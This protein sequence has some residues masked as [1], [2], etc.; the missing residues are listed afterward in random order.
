MLQARWDTYQSSIFRCHMKSM[1][2]QHLMAQM[3]STMQ[4]IYA[5]VDVKFL[6][7]LDTQM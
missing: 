4:T 6:K 5:L 2:I 7:F 3:R 1:F